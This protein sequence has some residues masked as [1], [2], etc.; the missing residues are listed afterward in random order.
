[1]RCRR[2]LQ[3]AVH[4]RGVRHVRLQRE[5]ASRA[6]P[7]QGALRPRHP[8]HR[9]ALA[10]QQLDDRAT[11]VARSEHNGASLLTLHLARFRRR[12]KIAA[13][14]LPARKAGAHT[15]ADGDRAR[16]RSTVRRARAGRKDS[17]TARTWLSAGSRRSTIEPPHATRQPVAI[18]SLRTQAAGAAQRAPPATAEARLARRR[19]CARARRAAR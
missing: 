10:D 13:R 1:M 5:R 4:A 2:L 8:R 11:Q 18:A 15:A 12:L 9:P 17:A 6:D 14:P 3:R 7:V 19:A 16:E